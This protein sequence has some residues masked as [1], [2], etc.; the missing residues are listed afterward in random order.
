VDL[1]PTRLRVM[2]LIQAN[3]TD[4][5]NASLAI[6]RNAAYLHQYITRGIPKVLPEDAREALASLLGVPDSE[7]RP[8]PEPGAR[9]PAELPELVTPRRRVRASADG[10]AAIPELDVRASAGAG[11]LNDGLEDAKA[12]WLFSETM[13]R[14]EFRAQPEDLRVITIDGDSMEPLL[15]SGDRILVDTSQRVPVPPGIFVIW[16]GMGIVAKRVE[17]IPNSDPAIVVI[18][19]VNPAYQTYERHAEEVHIVGRVIWAAKRL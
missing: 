10:F 1:D 14:H 7:I 3:G 11:A 5:K 4:L 19:S 17:H 15:S 12:T 18:K 2:A 8:P 9:P 6:G 16:D 13:I